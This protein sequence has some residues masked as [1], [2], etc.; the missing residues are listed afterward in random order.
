MERNHHQLAR[1]G[2]FSLKNRTPLFFRNAGKG[3]GGGNF[4]SDSLFKKERK[5]G[6]QKKKKKEGKEGRKE[7]KQA[8]KLSQCVTL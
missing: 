7:G 6:V 3:G 1:N 5:I 8:A 2:E 4:G